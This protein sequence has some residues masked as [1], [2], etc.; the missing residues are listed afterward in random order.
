[1]LKGIAAGSVFLPL[2]GG[3]LTGPVTFADGA[4]WASTGL[5]DAASYTTASTAMFSLTPTWNFSTTANGFSPINLSPTLVPTGATAGNGQGLNVAAAIGTSSVNSGT[6][7]G[8]SGSLTL[9]A[10]YAGTATVGVGITANVIN[11]SSGILP[12]AY[13]FFA[14]QTG[15][16]DGATSG[17][18]VN[19]G[20]GNSTTAAAAGAGGTM[21]N[22]G[23]FVNVPAGSSAG[24]TNAG[25]F[26][27]GN[28]GGAAA[29]NY[30]IFSNSTAPSVLGGSLKTSAPNG[31]TAGAWKFG[32]AASVSPTSPN[33]TIELDV[34]GTIYYL[35]AK[36]TNN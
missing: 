10:G 32:I 2:A 36:T 4:V 20:F 26:I 29:A 6:V 23:Y 19:N 21:A 17:S 8:I 9:N 12:T 34:G 13:S 35:A 28:G 30:A 3:T 11:S 5:S 16:G 31:G 7:R 24:T 1:M 25:I 33:R 22:N 15:N 18:V 14:S 27:T